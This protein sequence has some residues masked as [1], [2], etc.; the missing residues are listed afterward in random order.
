M[1][2]NSE[3][4][5]Q[6]NDIKL[7][8]FV[9]GR[10]EIDTKWRGRVEEPNLTRLYRVFSGS[11][12]IRYGNEVLILREGAWYL[13]PAGLSFD[14]L[15]EGR[16]DHLFFHLRLCG[17]SGID[18]LK[19]VTRPLSIGDFSSVQSFFEGSDPSLIDGLKM[20]ELA[21]SVILAMLDGECIDISGTRLSEPVDAAVGYI[22]DNLSAS[23]TVSAVAEA[24]GVSKSTLQKRFKAE[25]S[26]SIGEFID[27][28]VLSKARS[29]VSESRMTLGEISESLGFSDQFYFSRRFKTKYGVSPR[30]YRKRPFI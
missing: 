13:L 15:C 25:L 29:L 18:M 4:L 26:V 30:E 21:L 5:K 10:S 19:N 20:K 24:L 27:D 16:M 2:Y 1:F 17:K 28:A 12:K 23:L 6:L 7:Q 14:Y 11:A 22:G 3:I 8:F 9:V